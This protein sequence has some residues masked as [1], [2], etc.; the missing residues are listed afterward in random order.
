MP[1]YGEELSCGPGC[2][3]LGHGRYMSMTGLR[4]PTICSEFPVIYLSH[5]KKAVKVIHVS[6]EPIEH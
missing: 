4:A 6:P 1:Y 2:N 3:K 5:S